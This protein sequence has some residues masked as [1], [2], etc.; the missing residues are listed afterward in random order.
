MGS[1]ISAIA[2]HFPDEETSLHGLKRLE[3]ERRRVRAERWYSN[4]VSERLVMPVEFLHI[5]AP[6]E[7]DQ[8]QPNE[9]SMH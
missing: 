5:L 3:A 6:I 1:S 9:G 2:Y 8:L 7:D 4:I